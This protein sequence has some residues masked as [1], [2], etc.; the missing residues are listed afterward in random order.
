MELQSIK[1][2]FAIIG[3][4]PALNH[5]LKVAVQV[6]NTDL[7]RAHQRGKRRGQGSVFADHSC[8][9]QPQTQ[10]FYRGQLR[11]HS[12]RHHRLGTVRP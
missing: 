1:N 2:R 4:A 10:S 11:G 5:A 8:L 6:A 12:R 9:V 7:T 3:N